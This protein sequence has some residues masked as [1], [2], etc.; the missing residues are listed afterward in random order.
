MNANPLFRFDGYY[1]LADF[2]E[3]PNLHQVGRQW[4]TAKL[5]A[6]LTGVSHDEPQ[7]RGSLRYLL[8]LYAMSAVAWRCLLVLSLA[9]VL[10]SLQPLLG[11]AFAYG[12]MACWLAVAGTPLLQFFREIVGRGVW[13]TPYRMVMIAILTLCPTSVLVWKCRQPA[14]VVAPGIVE[15][16]PQEIVRVQ[17][18]G[19]V[20]QVCVENGQHVKAGDELLQ[21]VNNDLA[22]ESLELNCRIRKSQLLVQ[23]LASKQQ[24]GERANEE[25]KLA[26][27]LLRRNE[28]DLQLRGLTVRGQVRDGFSARYCHA[29]GAILA[30]RHRIGRGWQRRSEGNRG[31]RSG[32]RYRRLAHATPRRPL[33]CTTG[34]QRAWPLRARGRGPNRRRARSLRIRRCRLPRGDRFPWWPPRVKKRGIKSISSR[35]LIPCSRPSF[36]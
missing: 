34:E 33:P 29:G 15:Y 11:P 20:Q 3:V 14:V 5:Q 27:Y 4:I 1:L 18:P 21:L 7:L 19:F 13:P 35:R 6:L 8:P 30:R 10:L 12:L 25:A 36:N 23:S 24:L 31:R 2:W 22:L 16:A 32:R 17:T 26:A 9:L 28:L